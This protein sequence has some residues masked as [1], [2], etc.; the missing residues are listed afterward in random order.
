MKRSETLMGQLNTFWQKRETTLVT[1]E[2]LRNEFQDHS[3]L[4]GKNAEEVITTIKMCMVWVQ[5]RSFGEKWPGKCVVP[6]RKG[7]TITGYR[8]SEVDLKKE[9]GKVETSGIG[10]GTKRE[11]KRIWLKLVTEAFNGDSPYDQ[12][13]VNTIPKLKRIKFDV[14]GKMISDKNYRTMKA[15][16]PALLRRFEEAIQGNNQKGISS[17]TKMSENNRHQPDEVVVETK[18]TL[19]RRKK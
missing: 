19:V 14:A 5:Q 6:V 12:F 2:A 13:L 15:E 11:G 10:A 18:K 9:G 16:F 3:T 1:L 7:V 4:A 17:D 8:T